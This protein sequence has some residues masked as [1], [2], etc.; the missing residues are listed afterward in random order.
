MII[1][2]P[3][4]QTLTK[5]RIEA[6]LIVLNYHWKRADEPKDVHALEALQLHNTINEMP[7][8]RGRFTLSEKGD[9]VFVA[10]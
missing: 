10:H 7:N 3:A 6:I 5:E 9:I 1:T 2:Q 8:L 4:D